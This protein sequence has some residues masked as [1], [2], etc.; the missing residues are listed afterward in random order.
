MGV[1]GF[2]NLSPIGTSGVTMAAALNPCIGE[3]RCTAFATSCSPRC[4]LRCQSV[5]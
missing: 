2:D 3:W 4:A 1:P 5:E